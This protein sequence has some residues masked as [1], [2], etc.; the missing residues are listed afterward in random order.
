M[1]HLLSLICLVLTIFCSSI[2]AFA[3][4]IDYSEAF[5]GGTGYS[6]GS[7]QYDNWL[8]FRSALSTGNYSS[9]TV[10]GT[11]TAGISC[12]SPTT[13]TLIAN[14]LNSGSASSISCDGQSWK[15]G[16]C[17]T[18]IELTVGA[19]NICQCNTNAFT[20]RPTLSPGN[21]NWGGAGGGS[22]CGAPSQTLSISVAENTAPPTIDVT[23]PSV[24]DGSDYVA[25]FEFSKN[26]TGFALNDITV[27]NG[28]SSGFVTISAHSYTAIITPSGIDDVT[29]SVAAG[30]AQ[31][32]NGALLSNSDQAV[33]IY[34]PTTT[35]GGGT[36]QYSEDFVG[37]T[38]YP[39]GT[40]QY[41][42]WISFRAGLT[43]GNYNSITVSGTNNSAGISCTSPATSTLIATA[44]NS[45]STSSF[46]C[47]GQT[48]RTGTCG[49][50]IELTVGT[51]G[52]CQC[53][54]N[55]FTLRPT[56]FATGHPSWGS[57]GGG[58]TCNAPSQN[59]TVVLNGDSEPPLVSFTDVPATTDGSTPF[60]I[61]LT[62]SEIISGLTLAEI[63]TSLVN[64][65]AS[66][67][68]EIIPGLRYEVTIAPDSLAD[69]TIGLAAAVVQDAS[70][71]NNEV[72]G[73]QIVVFATPATL[74]AVKTTTVFD[75]L[76]EGLYALPGNDVIYTITVSNTGEGSVDDGSMLLIDRL[77]AELIF[78][79]G[80]ADGPGPETDPVIFSE[81]VGPTGLDAFDFT[82]D[83][84]F[85]DSTTQPA[86]FSECNYLPS[87]VLDEAITFVC[88]NPKGSLLGGDP[89]PS[90]SLSFRARIR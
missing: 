19:G 77:P 13:S 57:A 87:I 78:Y 75:P 38:S 18:G 49:N 48:W 56:I 34:V 55:A 43:A 86:D 4:T 80:D 62:F 70:G 27:L 26:V 52:I 36:D 82:N 21:A 11:N 65:T 39:V 24:H 2:S 40:T 3:Q 8:S 10:S 89:D 15:I 1:K 53:N 35:S 42:N 81:V 76:A 73:N 16:T 45:G 88:F 90:F 25:E 71:N 85:S 68:T 50:G 47:D 7:P 84:K 72:A 63:Q 20:L 67:L 33:T 17:G 69:V 23:A 12:S 5:V 79:N 29:V 61:T 9:I 58:S 59:L 51:G 37:G 32:S 6:P 66:S 46:T 44:L 54:S 31:D 14:A 83:V 60:T 41:D 30:T 74:E 64:G 28:T 22:T